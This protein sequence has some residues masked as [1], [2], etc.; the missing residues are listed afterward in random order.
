[1]SAG[2]TT[3]TRGEQQPPPHKEEAV[4]RTL[5]PAL[6]QLEKNLRGWLDGPH[7]FPLTVITRA[8]LEGIVTDLRRKADDLDVDRPLLVIVLMGGTGVGKST[9]LNAL[10]MDKAIALAS[11]QRPTT[12]DPVVYYHETVRPDRL[13]PVL[14]HCRLVPHDRPALAHKIIV[15][16]PDLDSNDLS[17]REKLLRILPVADVVLYVGSQEKYHDKLGWEIFLQQR[18]RRAFAFVLNKWDRCLHA[19]ASGIRPDEDM[20]HDL[21]AE[22]FANPLL[23][24]TCAQ[25]WV[26]YQTSQDGEARGD[27]GKPA[28]LPDGEQFR[29]LVHWLEMGLTRLEIEAI[30]ARGVSQLLQAIATTLHQAMPPDLS[31]PATR[32]QEAWRDILKEEGRSIAEILVN[33]LEPYQREIEHHFALEGQRRFRNIMAGY[34]QMF[35]RFRYMGSSLRDRLPMVGKS[36]E[37]SAAPAAWDLSTFTRACSDAAA[38]RSLDARNKALVNR[39][40]VAADGQKYP[41]NVLSE[42]VESA[43]RLDWRH[44]YA[45]TVVEALSQVEQRWVEPRGGRRIIQLVLVTLANWVPPLAFLGGWVLLLWKVSMVDDF[46]AGLSD[47][48]MPFVIVLAVLVIFH[49]LI[50][51]L[52]PMRWPAIRGEFQESL[53]EHL[54][55]ELGNTFAGIPLGVAEAL[56]AERRKVESLQQEVGEVA[57]W[58]QKREEAARNAIAALYGH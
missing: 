42:P 19:F 27:N 57:A 30:K 14:R 25:R 33:T 39:L 4:L 56:T 1:M 6:R 24:R 26:D 15:D 2:D 58:L 31:E 40:L 3:E 12:R 20:L 38:S 48:L 52:L 13:D 37:A 55:R 7:R 16:T 17:N 34:L 22:G 11:V 8:A 9:L 50:A 35:M 28:G 32:T 5:S 23:F 36:R 10:A 47:L 53:A 49:I 54:E 18:K 41:L 43:G 21:K 45:Q 51:I 29:E 46:H 44:R